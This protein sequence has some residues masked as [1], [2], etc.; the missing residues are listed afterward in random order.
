MASLI[1]LGGFMKVISL[2]P[3]E[4]KKYLVDPEMLHKAKRP[5]A[6]IIKLIY[7][8]KRLDFAVPFRSNISPSAPTEQYFPLPPRGTTKDGHR[9][10]LHYIKMFPVD[11]TKV[12]KFHMD[13][14]YY[15]IIY[16]ILNR[17]EK[18]IIKDCQ[19]YL[20]RYENGSRPEYSTDI[21]LLIQILEENT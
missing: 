12:N 7:R 11:K 20:R 14:M 18:R 8:G 13:D 15:K 6:L 10:G 21:D 9:H 3:Q 4:L 2:K 1:L 19:D 16:A 5:C 17:N